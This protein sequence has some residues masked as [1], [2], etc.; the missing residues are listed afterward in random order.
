MAAERQGNGTILYTGRLAP[1]GQWR[2]GKTHHPWQPV[3]EEDKGRESNAREDWALADADFVENFLVMR[4]GKAVPAE[5][6][7]PLI[8]LRHSRDGIRDGIRLQ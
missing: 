3:G 1:V 7:T 5:S 2:R 4:P 6:G 8:S